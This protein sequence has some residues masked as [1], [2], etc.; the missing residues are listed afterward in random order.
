MMRWQE[1]MGGNQELVNPRVAHVVAAKAFA[2]G[3]NSPYS[4]LRTEVL[5]DFLDDIRVFNDHLQ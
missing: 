4:N 1:A 2:S 3:C 5:I